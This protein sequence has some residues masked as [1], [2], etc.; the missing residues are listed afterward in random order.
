MSETW[1]LVPTARRERDRWIYGERVTAVELTGRARYTGDHRIVLV[2]VLDTGERLWLSHTRIAEAE[3][4][5][6][7]M[8]DDVR[9]TAAPD[10]T[11]DPDRT[12]ARR[13]ARWAARSAEELAARAA[14]Q[15]RRRYEIRG[16]EQPR[17]T[18]L[19]EAHGEADE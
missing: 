7:A 16:V 18:R 2:L 4:A 13:R 11:V 9:P 8:H 19:L 12:R 17:S 14:A 15:R 3:A 1:A 10:I 6:A 5:A